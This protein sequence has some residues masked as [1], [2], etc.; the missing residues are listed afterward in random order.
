MFLRIKPADT[1]KSKASRIVDEMNVVRGLK[2]YDKI[3]Y[4]ILLLK[5]DNGLK[6]LFFAHNVTP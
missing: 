4:C 5:T 6:N 3:L 2:V 1:S